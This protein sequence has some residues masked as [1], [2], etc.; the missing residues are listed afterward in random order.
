MKIKFIIFLVF[1]FILTLTL[2][3]GGPS[4]V[5]DLILING[6]IVTVNQNF[7]I[8][9]AVAIKKDKILAVGSNTEIRKFANRLTKIIDL[10]GRTV[11]PGL[12]DAHAHPESASL[13]ELEEEIPDVHTIK[14]LLNWIKSQTV[15]KKQHEWIIFPRLFFTRLK[16]LRQPT[17][18]ELDSVAPDDPVLLN[19]SYG[20]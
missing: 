16:E 5:A 10:K 17:L 12:T 11:I 8:A 7:S 19:E 2:V 20:A 18:A 6:K 9:E 13:S 4:S 14:E 15:N 3:A 1:Q